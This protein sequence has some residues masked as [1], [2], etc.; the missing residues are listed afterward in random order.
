MLS[1]SQCVTSVH[2]I[3][4]ISC[5]LAALSPCFNRKPYFKSQAFVG[6]GL[7]IFRIWYL[8]SWESSTQCGN[9]CHL[10]FH[11]AVHGSIEY[12]LLLT[13]CLVF[14]QNHFLFFHCSLLYKCS[15]DGNSYHY[16][17][18]GNISQNYFF[19]GV[20]KNQKLT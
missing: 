12:I 16:V 1:V 19:K 3:R 11:P 5:V 20:K 18:G 2:R 8:S 9:F 6:L 15:F 14:F 10:S 7:G 17:Q 13:L 4:W